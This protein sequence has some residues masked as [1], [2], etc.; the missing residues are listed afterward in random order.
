[1]ATMFEFSAGSPALCL[2]DTIGD[3]GG[4][5]AERLLASGDLDRWLREAS[6]V[7]ND[8]RGATENDLAEARVLRD[9]VYR[10]AMMLMD[11]EPPES[12]DIEII[13]RIARLA[14]PS[15]QWRDG[16]VVPLAEDA[17]AAAFSLIA[18]DA[19]A[20]L[21]APCIER[22]RLCPECRMMFLDRSAAGR[23]RWCSSASGCGNRAKVREHRLRRAAQQKE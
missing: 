16:K 14:P 4:A 13:N 6:L 1:M 18:A 19:V 11:R 12:A 2:I 3:R 5:C 9:A 23:R 20:I 7:G 10:S 22:V 15:P 17:I 8:A 21:A